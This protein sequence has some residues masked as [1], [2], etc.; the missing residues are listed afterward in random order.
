M[1]DAPSG[2][3]VRVGRMSPTP[4]PQDSRSNAAEAWEKGLRP[5]RQ[6]IPRIVFKFHI[7]IAQGSAPC[8]LTA[9][10]RA[11]RASSRLGVSAQATS[12]RR[13]RSSAVSRTPG[14]RAVAARRQEL[15]QRGTHVCLGGVVARGED[16]LER[17]SAHDEGEL[18]RT[19]ELCG[20]GVDSEY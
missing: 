9:L 10:I 19:G 18:R 12:M 11:S 17:V 8:S 4:R 13:S 3:M 1:Y 14:S 2:A 6:G 5:L 16:A 20:W 7:C 15:V